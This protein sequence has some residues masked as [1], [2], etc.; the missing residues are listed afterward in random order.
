LSRYII[1]VW[2][3]YKLLLEIVVKVIQKYKI[4]IKDPSIVDYNNI[5]EFVAKSTSFKKAI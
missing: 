3:L 5:C 2:F 4:N 1:E